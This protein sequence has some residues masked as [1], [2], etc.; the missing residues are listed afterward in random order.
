MNYPEGLN[1]YKESGKKI[2]NRHSYSERVLNSPFFLNVND[3]KN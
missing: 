3:P 2:Q 1:Y